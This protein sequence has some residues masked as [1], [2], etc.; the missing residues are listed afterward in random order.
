MILCAY[1]SQKI[2]FV[3]NKLALLDILGI[4]VLV[5]VCLLVVMYLKIVHQIILG[6]LKRACANI[7]AREDVSPQWF[8]RQDFHGTRKHAIVFKIV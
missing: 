4:G 6:I 8:A 7:L 3:T 5:L 1:V 2:P